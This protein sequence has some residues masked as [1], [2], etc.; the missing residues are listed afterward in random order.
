MLVISKPDVMALRL[1]KKQGF[2]GG[3]KGV[4]RCRGGRICFVHISWNA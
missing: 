4:I 3:V 2:W 1:F